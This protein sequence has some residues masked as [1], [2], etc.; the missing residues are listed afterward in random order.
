[1]LTEITSTNAKTLFKIWRFSKKKNSQNQSVFPT[2][3]PPTGAESPKDYQLK[4]FE[5]TV[6][7]V[8]PVEYSYKELSKLS[9]YIS[10]D[11][12]LSRL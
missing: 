9:I 7:L 10:L 1:M 2:K 8:L 6:F 5:F 3:W 4:K 11:H 12:L